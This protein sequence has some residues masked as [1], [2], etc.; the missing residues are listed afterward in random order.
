M[1]KSFFKKTM[2]LCFAVF[3]MVMI[4][5]NVFATDPNE[6]EEPGDNA[7]I[8]CSQHALQG[9]TNQCWEPDGNGGCR[10]TGAMSDTCTI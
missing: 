9:R 7:D 1:K 4:G 5:N 3:G 2:I 10:W 6:S 8:T